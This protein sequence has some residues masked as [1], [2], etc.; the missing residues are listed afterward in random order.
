[1]FFRSLAEAKK[2]L[3]E[4]EVFYLDKLCPFQ[5]DETFCGTWC[6][7]CRE[8]SQRDQT[9]GKFATV[10]LNVNCGHSGFRA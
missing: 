1:M 2:A 4:R 7:L 3:K 9:T 8:E 5:N 10:A 6:P